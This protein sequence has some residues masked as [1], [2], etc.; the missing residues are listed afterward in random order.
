[1]KTQTMTTVIFSV[2]ALALFKTPA[3][4]LLSPSP[5]WSLEFSIMK[6]GDALCSRNFQNVKSGLDFV[7]IGSFLSPLI[8]HVKSNFGEFKLSKNVIF[9]NFRRSEI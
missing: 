6:K 7:E 9:G 8:F 2:R 3:P 5:A 4:D 1:M